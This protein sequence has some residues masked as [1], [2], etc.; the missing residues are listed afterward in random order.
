M[1][2]MIVTTE[3]ER[4]HAY[5]VREEVFVKEQHVPIELEIDELEEEAVQFVGYKNNEPIAASRM[6]FVDDYA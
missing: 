6:R 4:Q 1:D 3:L 2:I 5:Q